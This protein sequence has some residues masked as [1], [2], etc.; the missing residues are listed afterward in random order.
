LRRLL[1]FLMVLGLLASA[2]PATAQ[3]AIV[4]ELSGIMGGR[5][6]GAIELIHTEG[7][8]ASLVGATCTGVAETENN[9]SVHEQNNVIVETGTTTA[10]FFGVEDTPG[11]ITPLSGPVVLGDTIDVYFQW[12]PDGITSLGIIITITCAPAQVTTTTTTT[13]TTTEPP[14]V[15]TTTTTTTTTEPP[16][17]TTLPTTTTS[18]TTTTTTP[19]ITTTTGGTPE[20]AVG[21]GGGGTAVEPGHFGLLVLGVAGTALASAGATTTWRRRSQS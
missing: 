3:T 19:I 13:T 7:V 10:T 1:L 16:V 6:E 14:P 20:G 18:T 4:I 21:A 17:V 8:D 11:Q 5:T 12:G 2:A 15:V 9:A